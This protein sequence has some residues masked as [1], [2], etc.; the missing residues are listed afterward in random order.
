MNDFDEMYPTIQCLSFT[1][2]LK[3]RYHYWDEI[4]DVF[5]TIGS[6]ENY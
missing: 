5:V 4:C 1:E 2:V 6:C 3:R